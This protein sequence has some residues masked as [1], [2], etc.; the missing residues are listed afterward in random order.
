MTFTKGQVLCFRYDTS[1]NLK[2]LSRGNL[3]RAGINLFEKIEHFLNSEYKSL[4]VL[5]KD[6]F[7]H[8]GMVR[9]V[10]KDKVIIQEALGTTSKVI[11]SEYTKGFLNKLI[12]EDRLKIID[13]E[14]RL[15]KDDNKV[16]EDYEGRKYDYYNV[17]DKIL[18]VANKI[19]NFLHLPQIPM[20][21]FSN[22]NKLVYCSELSLW[23]LYEFAKYRGGISYNSK[24]YTFLNRLRKKYNITDI[25]DIANYCTPQ[26]FVEL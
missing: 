7:T 6:Y 22:N 16:F 5:R 2:K 11:S 15:N 3:V 25:E 23:C 18:R 24:F 14:F 17:L 26:D 20:D 10:K 1:I 19:T 12:K 21:L 13:F 8:T 9:Q 4:R